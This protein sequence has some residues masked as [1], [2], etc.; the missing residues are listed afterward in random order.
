[1]ISRSVNA[2]LCW[3]RNSFT[4]VQNSQPGCEYSVTVF[5]TT[6]TLLE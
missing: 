4:R 6:A 5:A 3:R 2:M 1:V